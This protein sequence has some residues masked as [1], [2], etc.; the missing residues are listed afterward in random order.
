MFVTL[1]HCG[2]AWTSMNGRIAHYISEPQQV[3]KDDSTG[4]EGVVYFQLFGQRC[5]KCMREEFQDSLHYPEEV[6]KV[7]RIAL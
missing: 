3:I 4:I 5:Q 2:N 1:Q 6:I 7:G